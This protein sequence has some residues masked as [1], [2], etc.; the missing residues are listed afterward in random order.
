MSD[1][2]A[3]RRNSALLKD[4]RLEMDPLTIFDGFYLSLV[5]GPGWFSTV[6]CL[7]PPR[8]ISG[9]DC[10]IPAQMSGSYSEIADDKPVTYCSEYFE[11]Q[12]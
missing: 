9:E 5:T 3:P 12:I 10:S 6:S 11:Y 2:G 7:P 4:R 8:D 1:A